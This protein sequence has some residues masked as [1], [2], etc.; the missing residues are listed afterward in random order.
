MARNKE[1]A[2]ELV[3]YIRKSHPK[4]RIQGVSTFGNAWVVMVKQRAGS[5]DRMLYIRNKSHWDGLAK[6]TKRLTEVGG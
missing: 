3:E 2:L 4:A 5:T 6:S 1:A